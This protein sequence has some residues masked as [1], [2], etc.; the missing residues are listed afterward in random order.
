MKGYAD[1][2]A[3]LR[4]PLTDEDILGYMLASF[5]AEYE[6]LVASIYHHA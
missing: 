2:M 6:S 5:R 4:H 1:T 3:S